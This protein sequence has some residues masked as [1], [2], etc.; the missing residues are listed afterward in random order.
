MSATSPHKV[1]VVDDDEHFL[2][3]C[4]AV[5]RRAGF[6]VDGV[7]D[8]LEALTR[9][10]D[11]RYDAVVSDLCMPALSGVSFLQAVRRADASVPLVLMSGSPTVESAISA[12]DL[13]VRKYLT[14]PFDI[15]VLINSI[16]EAAQGTTRGAQAAVRERFERGLAGIAMA[17]Q[18]I[19]EFSERRAFA[20][21][22]LLRTSAS[23]VKGPGDL[24]GMAEQLGRVHELGRAVRA[25][26]AAVLNQQD[27]GADIFVNLHPADLADA[28]LF[29]PSAPLTAYARR[30]VL[31][32]TERASVSNEEHLSEQ[33]RA[34][35]Q[36]GYR[37]AVDDLG[38]GYSGLT[39]LARVQPE[40]VKLD[41]SLVRHIN[42]SSVNQLVVTAVSDLSRELGLRVVAECIET[43]QELETLRA[44]GIELLQGYLFAKPAPPFT[45]VDFARWESA[46]QL[47][48]KLTG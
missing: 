26:V 1:L 44:L 43:A 29:S 3:V 16:A 14:K 8:P 21:E 34:L 31:E 7:G 41:G 19:V 20:Y 11:G 6:E 25:N 30:V 46:P 36:L 47:A 48:Q 13:G 18:P 45:R 32:I 15:D 17:F 38:A 37:V 24:L 23:D 40:F 39:T 28:E 12:I 42:T 22:A 5:L 2:K 27:P 9:L 35:R 4:L 33:I 10:G